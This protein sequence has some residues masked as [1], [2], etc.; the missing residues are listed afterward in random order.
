VNPVVRV[1]R[2]ADGWQQRSP[3]LAFAFAV[4][5]KFGD[6]Q[7]GGLAGL[8]AYYA[9]FSVFP[10]LL[11]FVTVVGFV[12]GSDNELT[13]RA[14]NSFPVIG[15]EIARGSL[16]GSGLALIL[17]MLLAVWAG[18][19]VVQAM[20]EAMNRVWNVP[21]TRRPGFLER[22]GRSLVMLVILGAAT[23]GA[24]ILSGVG[25]SG[26][27][28][29]LTRV[30]GIALALAVNIGLYLL[31][32]RVLTEEHLSW[33]AV[34]PGALIA[35]VAWTLLQLLGGWYVGHQIAGA[36]QTYGVFAVVIGLLTWLYL[37]AQASLLAAEVNV[38]RTRRLWPRSLAPPPL[39]RADRD[40]FRAA[41]KEAARRPEQTVSVRFEEPPAE[42]PPAEHRNR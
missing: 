40:V 30:A 2:A 32:F 26:A 21:M 4:V 5:R 8:I 41:A 20:Q 13:S 6:D 14:L 31:A 28:G 22:L 7:A 35:G 15:R 17:G 34:L 42:A 33:G 10:L 16:R 38:V 11:V 25:T 3:L 9:F 23:I 29:T 24:T 37:G 39:T 18:M 19:R 27:V 36:S 1:A 12:L